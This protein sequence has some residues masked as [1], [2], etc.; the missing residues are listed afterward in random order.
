MRIFGLNEA[1]YY[2]SQ[3]SRSTGDSEKST[4][5]FQKK[6][7]GTRHRTFA[8]GST[9]F[10]EYRDCSLRDVERSLFF[11]ASHY[12][13]SLDL[14]I[15]SSSPWAHVTLYYGSWYAS[16]ALLGLFGCTIFR[17]R[18]VVD[19]DRG[20]PGHQALRL[21]RE[22]TTY[23]GSHQIFWDLFYRTVQSLKP[24][25]LAHQAIVLSPIGGDPVWQIDKRNDVNYD[26][27]LSLRLAK[28]FDRVFSKDH[29]PT[30]LPGVLNSQFRIL[31]TLLEIVYTYVHDFGLSTDS[32]DGL[33]TSTSLCYKVKQLIY[34][35]KPP[36][37]VQKT[38]KAII[39]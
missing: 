39:T 8:E 14:M 9:L 29:F 3:F 30:C 4:V 22:T 5:E 25:L 17:N 15:L 20:S 34:N 10:E 31:E 19:V 28:D 23:N 2:C 7:L 18:L 16:H 26:S 24:M 21:R 38:K 32:L 1:T 6:Y 13:R 12:R 35:K 27:F 37:L 33:T 36:G 11:A